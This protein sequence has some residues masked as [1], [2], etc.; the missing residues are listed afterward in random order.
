MKDVNKLR[1]IGYALPQVGDNIFA[2][3]RKVGPVVNRYPS[4]IYTV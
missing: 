4:P 2:V 1:G 3:V